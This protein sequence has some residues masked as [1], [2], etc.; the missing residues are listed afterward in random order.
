MEGHTDRN[1]IVPMRCV[2]VVFDQDKETGGSLMFDF[3]FN[4]DNRHQ[5]TFRLEDCTG[6]TPEQIGNQIYEWA[7]KLRGLDEV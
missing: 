3:N 7:E 6:L 2:G 1:M 5:V 4:R